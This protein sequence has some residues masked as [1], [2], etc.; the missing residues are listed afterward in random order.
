MTR[1]KLERHPTGVL[2]PVLQ[3]TRAQQIRY[4][5]IDTIGIA[6]WIF[7]AIA[8]ATVVVGLVAGLFGVGPAA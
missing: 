7:M 5:V 4:R 2:H 6:F 1:H 3:P 8:L